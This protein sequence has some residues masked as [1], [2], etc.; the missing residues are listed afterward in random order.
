M[1]DKNYNQKVDSQDFKNMIKKHGVKM[2]GGAI[3]RLVQIFDEDSNNEITKKEVWFA[4]DLYNCKSQNVTP[5]DTI[6]P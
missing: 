2:D 3:N 5:I 6:S 4:L 1:C